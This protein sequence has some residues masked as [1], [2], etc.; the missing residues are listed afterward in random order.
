MAE[1][2]F[3]FFRSLSLVNVVFIFIRI[4]QDDFNLL[5]IHL[6]RDLHVEKSEVFI[7]IE[8]IR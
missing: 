2:T 1:K 4:K 8:R 5:I 6:E 3:L 7:N